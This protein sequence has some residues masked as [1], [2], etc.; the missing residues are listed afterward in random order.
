MAESTD[1]AVRRVLAGTP[2]VA[3]V[4]FS[5]NPARPS[6]SVAAFLRRRG[7]RVI[8]V[9]PG[10]AGQT[11]G[12]EVAVARLADITGAVDIVDVFRRTE[13]LG[14]V[15]DEALALDPL[16]GCI[17]MQLGLRD[18]EG[19]ARARARGVTVIEDRCPAVEAPRLGL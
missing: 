18:A 8:P 10:L 1:D 11:F 13:D 4:G 7:C 3:V 6:H 15:V 17:W 19:A 16:P 14:G 2:T 5:A 12:G 9:S